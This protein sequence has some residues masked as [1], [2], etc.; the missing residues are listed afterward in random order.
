MTLSSVTDN[1]IAALGQ[2]N[3]VCKVSLDL[4]GWQL[5]NVLAAMQSHSRSRQSCISS[6]AVKS[7]VVK[8]C[9]SFPIRSW[10]DLLHRDSSNWN[11]M[12]FRFQD[13]PNLFLSATHL[14]IPHSGYISPKAMVACLPVL[15]NLSSMTS[16]LTAHD[17]NSSIVHQNSTHSMNPLC[18]SM[19]SPAGSHV[20]TGHPS[21]ASG[22][23]R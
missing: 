20:D 6:Y 9:Q 7:D 2:S 1:V 4:A 13:C 16:I 17:P 8:R 19:M 14:I 3:R 15:S 21:L 12:P 11:W 18:N 10:V 5:E 22:I 23:L